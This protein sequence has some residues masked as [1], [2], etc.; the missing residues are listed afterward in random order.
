MQKSHGIVKTAAKVHKP[1][2]CKKPTIDV[3]KILGDFVRKWQGDYRNR[4][5]D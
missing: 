4:K 2:H 3:G 1:N 5:E